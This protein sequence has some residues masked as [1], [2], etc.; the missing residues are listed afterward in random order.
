VVIIKQLYIA[1]SYVFYDDVKMF[2]FSLHKLRIIFADAWQ[3]FAIL[4]VLV[5]FPAFQ[6]MEIFTTAIVST[7]DPT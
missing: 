6:K 3:M 7:S 5:T 4:A 1:R 2:L